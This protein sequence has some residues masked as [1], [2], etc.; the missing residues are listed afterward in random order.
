MNTG[1]LVE[2]QDFKKPLGPPLGAYKRQSEGKW[3]F[4]RKF[5]YADVWVDLEQEEGRITWK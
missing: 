5:K 3:I 4:T 2:F 1:A